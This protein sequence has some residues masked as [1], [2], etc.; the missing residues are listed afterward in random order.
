MEDLGY[1]TKEELIDEDSD[2]G[3][4]YREVDAPSVIPEGDNE[5]LE[6][7]LNS[8]QEAH[9]LKPKKN[10]DSVELKHRPETVEDY[11]RNFLFRKKMSK[12]LACFQAEW[13]G[14][15]RNGLVDEANLEVPD[16]YVQNS[17]LLDKVERLEKR[18]NLLEDALSGANKNILQLKK[19]RDFHK[20]AHRGIKTE[21]SELMSTIDRIQDQHDDIIKE[22]KTLR[23]RYEVTKRKSTVADIKLEKTQ[24]E[25]LKVTMR[26]TS[27]SDDGE[28][29]KTT[30]VPKTLSETARPSAMSSSQLLPSTLLPRDV[31]GENVIPMTITRAKELRALTAFQ[32]HDSAVSSMA[33]NTLPGVT[34]SVLATGCDDGS[35][36]LWDIGGDNN[37]EMLLHT[38]AHNNWI[39]GLAFHPQGSLLLTGSGDTTVK[40]WDLG[41]HECVG[42]LVDHGHAVWDI[43]VHHTGSAAVSASLDCTVKL[44][45][46]QST[47]CCSTFRGHDDSV[48]SARFQSFSNLLV[49]A[50]GDHRVVLWDARTGFQNMIFQGHEN[51]CNHATFNAQG[52][53]IASVDADGVV[54]LFEVRNGKCIASF[55]TLSTAT[56]CSFDAS[57]SVLAVAC[58]DKSTRILDVTNLDL[59]NKLDG[60]YEAVQSVIF[61]AHGRYAVTGADDGGVRVWGA[62]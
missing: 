20:L 50:G 7:T 6:K 8:V 62:S 51:A 41:A 11:L 57:G 61:E 36:R 10:V 43:D 49:T 33:I 24:Q 53:K 5:P 21:N 23:K 16:C 28:P 18:N 9:Q 35:F 40:L 54:K 26:Q 29:N 42:S 44:W 59:V 47:T 25:L 19:E 38:Q 58:D 52:D 37:G 1:T 32:A 27:I 30:E 12:T 4:E 46:L 55:S 60:H 3:F 14:M 17:Q 31:A 56:Y 15:V 45:D 48:N 2:D 13:Y 34:S 22:N 39:G